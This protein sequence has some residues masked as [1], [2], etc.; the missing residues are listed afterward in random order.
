MGWFE[1]FFTTV[2]RR[3]KVF[4]QDYLLILFLDYELDK[5]NIKDAKFKWYTNLNFIIPIIKNLYSNR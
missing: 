5:E 4:L 3:Y 2:R 1:F